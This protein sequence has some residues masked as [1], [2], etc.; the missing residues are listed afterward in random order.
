MKYLDLHLKENLIRQ[1][2]FLQKNTS[3][4][5]ASFR[6]KGPFINDVGNF[7]EFLTPPP[8]CRQVLVLSIGNFDQSPSQLPTSFI[9]GPQGGFYSEYT[10]CMM[11]MLCPGF[12]AAAEVRT[13]RHSFITGWRFSYACYA[14]RMIYVMASSKNPA[15]CTTGNGG[16]SS[17]RPIDFT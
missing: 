14:C 10:G 4:K 15:L 5:P 13:V 7:S 12:S 9:D 17:S 2:S 16:S 8:P 11:R 1:T 3:Q 6:V